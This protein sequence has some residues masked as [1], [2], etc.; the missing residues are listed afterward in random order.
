MYGVSQIISKV[1]ENRKCFIFHFMLIYDCICNEYCNVHISR[2][3]A[4]YF[5]VL[6]ECLLNAD[7]V[8][9]RN[10]KGRKRMNP[11]L[12][13]SKTLSASRVFTI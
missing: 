2:T 7:S 4:K 6:L 12:R 3:D 1:A 9:P 8:F 11:I 10:D 5:S 13:I